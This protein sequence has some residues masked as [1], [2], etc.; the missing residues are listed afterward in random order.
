MEELDGS[1]SPSTCISTPSILPEL[2]HSAAG[3]GCVDLAFAKE[4][5]KMNA[6]QEIGFNP[7][8]M[9]DVVMDCEGS[10]E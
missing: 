8:L 10:S 3:S 7:I 9:N 6:A 2:C 5:A 4:L 1:L